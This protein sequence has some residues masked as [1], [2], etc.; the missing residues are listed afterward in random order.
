MKI[1]WEANGL[2]IL[3]TLGAAAGVI[4][5][6]SQYAADLDTKGQLLRQRVERVESDLAT[7]KTKASVDHDLLVEIRADL[8]SLRVQLDR[9]ERRRSAL[10]LDPS[11]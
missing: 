6:V 7:L 2:S 9:F 1:N 5:T 10:P 11:P 4:V 3:A 8:K